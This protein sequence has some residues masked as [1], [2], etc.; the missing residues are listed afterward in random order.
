M[1][2]YPGYDYLKILILHDQEL[3]YDLR[4][5]VT[6]EP[7]PEVMATPTGISPHVE[8]ASQLTEILNN[9]TKVVSSL[10]EQTVQIT[11]AVNCGI[12]AMSL[13][14]DCDK[15]SPLSRTNAWML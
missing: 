14:G 4:L 5:L 7:T 3:L 11:E 8:L 9:V 1:V 6:T 12:W 10:Q 13:G 15:V 2:A